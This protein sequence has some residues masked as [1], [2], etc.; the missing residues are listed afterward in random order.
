MAEKHSKTGL[1]DVEVA[2]LHA[3]IDTLAA[4]Y[5][6]KFLLIKGEEVHGAYDSLMEG[7]RAAAKKFPTSP[8]LV[9]S[10]LHPEEPVEHYPSFWA[11]M[12][13]VGSSED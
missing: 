10:V 7:A 5:P 2:Y 6:G 11:D 4:K 12:D 1:L 13:L 8:T 9:R 3:N